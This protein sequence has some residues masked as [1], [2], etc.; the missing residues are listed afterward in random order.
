MHAWC[1]RIFYNHFA[2]NLLLNL[3][4]K[5]FEFRLRSVRIMARDGLKC[6]EALSRIIIR[7]QSGGVLVWLSV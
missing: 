2:A 7:G 1:G 4:V 5:K 6:M 3:T